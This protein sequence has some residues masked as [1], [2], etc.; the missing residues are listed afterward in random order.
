M[1]TGLQ[2]ASHTIVRE[3]CGSSWHTWLHDLW[4]WLGLHVAFAAVQIRTF[5]F[6]LPG[7]LMLCS[8]KSHLMTAS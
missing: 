1:W 4:D 7:T 8:P 6:L 2:H 5:I 3:G